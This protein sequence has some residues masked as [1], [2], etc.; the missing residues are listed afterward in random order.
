MVERLLTYQGDQR[1]FHPQDPQS[2]PF[3]TFCRAL[4][5]SLGAPTPPR[6]S[7]ALIAA[8]A[9]ASKVFVGLTYGRFDPGLQG[10]ER[11]YGRS[12][13]THDGE[14]RAA[15]NWQPDQRSVEQAIPKSI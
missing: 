12:F 7:P 15:L 6:V 13:T 3:P 11:L 1:V 2:P 10:I 9:I 14:T 8:G 4:A 5:A